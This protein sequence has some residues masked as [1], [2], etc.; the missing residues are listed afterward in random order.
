MLLV[1]STVA[2]LAAV[3]VVLCSCV[4][5]FSLRSRNKVVTG[6]ETPS[7][8]SWVVL[9]W[10]GTNYSPV[11]AHFVPLRTVFRLY[12]IVTPYLL[13]V[14]F[15]PALQSTTTDINEFDASPGIM[16]PFLAGIGKSS[17]S[18]MHLCID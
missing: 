1:L 14:A 5:A 8:V 17:R 18:N 15:Y 7:I 10:S 9:L 3:Y 4:T 16:C 6:S 11:C 12:S 2:T 13:N